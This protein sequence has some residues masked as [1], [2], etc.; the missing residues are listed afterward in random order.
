M[1]KRRIF[2]FGDSF[3]VGEGA[4][5][6]LTSQVLKVF[7]E[8]N[9]RDTRAASEVIR[10]IN[11]KLS[12]TQHIENAFNIFVTNHGE[13]GA[14]NNT[15]FNKV[16]EVD[17]Y[18][19]FGPEDLVIVMWS[20]SVR[21]K[22]PFF[23]DN[24]QQHGPIGAGWSLK[25][26]L[27][28]DNENLF[29]RRFIYDDDDHYDKKY[30]QYIEKTLTPFMQ[31]YFKEYLTNFHSNEYY[32]IVNLNYIKL[33]QNYFKFKNT[34][35][36][37]IDAFEQMNSFAKKQDKRWGDID[38]TFYFGKGNT[39]IWDELNKIGGDVW[40]D[41]KLTVSPDGQRC[42]PNKTGY[43]LIG[44]IL[45]KYVKSNIKLYKKSTI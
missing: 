14:S 33:L 23:P 39:T 18:T 25:E 40:E 37:M 20:S 15:I 26:L 1:G 43:K 4:D 28:S 11:L 10:S 29:S 22:L 12:W 3:T 41:K 17:S 27:G 45:E 13:T 5:L 31:S 8:T 44:E 34:N 9:E 21:D 2:A 32:N 6:A 24:F 7:K 38:T 42:H 19:D 16:F 35:Y 30:L 36:I